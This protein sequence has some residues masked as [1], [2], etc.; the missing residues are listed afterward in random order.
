[1]RL[2]D[3]GCPSCGF[4]GPHPIVETTPPGVVGVLTVECG[5]CFMEFTV[6]LVPDVIERMTD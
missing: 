1:M 6:T 2:N 3:Y 4:D 5:S